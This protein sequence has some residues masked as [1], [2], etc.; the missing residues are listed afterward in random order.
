MKVHLHP[1]QLRRLVPAASLCLVA[2]WSGS[3]Q[4]L[5]VK[6]TIDPK[7]S[8]AWWQ[9]VP[10]LGHLWASTCPQDPSWLPGEGRTWGPGGYDV[11][12]ATQ[13]TEDS[14]KVPIPLFPRYRIRSVCAEAVHG[15]IVTP[16]SVTWKGAHGKVVVDAAALTQVSV[17]RDAFAHHV[18]LD[19]DE[20]PKIVLTIDSVVNV[21]P[22]GPSRDTLHAVAVGTLS[23]HGVDAPLRVPVVAWHDGGGL[24]VQGRWYLHPTDLTDKYQVPK[25]VL[26]LG[27]GTRIWKELWVGTDL[28]MRPEPTAP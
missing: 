23:L 3:P 24:R 21:M 11:A 14:S 10:H 6:F 20:H 9:V 22:S 13:F 15:E 2:A 19:V 27:V 17:L 16:D 4:P 8:L 1:T 28:V 25:V 18:V 7:S 12:Q 26:S 5:G